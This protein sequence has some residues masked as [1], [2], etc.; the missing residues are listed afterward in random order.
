MNRITSTMLHVCFKS[1]RIQRRKLLTKRF[2]LNRFF[3]YVN[4]WNA[5]CIHVAIWN[6]SGLEYSDFYVHAQTIATNWKLPWWW[7]EC[8]FWIGCLVKSQ[9][10]NHVNDVNKWGA[11]CFRK[12]LHWIC[13]DSCLVQI[14]LGKLKERKLKFHLPAPLWNVTIVV[15]PQ[16]DTMSRCVQVESSI[17]FCSPYL[18]LLKQEPA[19]NA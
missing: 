5:K 2:F 1:S 3:D 18:I 19:L 15:P 17:Q 14:L 6:I 7:P 9:E 11:S 8:S 16:A 13:F 4:I 12:L 10:S